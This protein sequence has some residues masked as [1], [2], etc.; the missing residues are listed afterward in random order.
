MQ[1]YTC[2]M[3][4]SFDANGN[5]PPGIHHAVLEEI[6]KRFAYTTCRRSLFEGLRTLVE[7]LRKANCTCLYLNGSFITNKE[8][9]NDYDACWEIEDINQRI[10]PLLLNPFQQLAEIKAKYKGDVFPRI[11]EL[12]RGIDHLEIF[13]RDIDTNPKGI[14]A[15]NLRYKK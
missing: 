13:Q 1:R 6:E 11:P 10:D 5:L 2:I 9:P 15:I 14:I 3:I 12:L 8:S 7:E 4:P